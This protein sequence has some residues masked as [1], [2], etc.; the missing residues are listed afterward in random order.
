[1][2]MTIKTMQLNDRDLAILDDLTE[3]GIVDTDIIRRRHFPRD[4]SGKACLR[5]LRLFAA[6]DLLAVLP[7]TVS[8]GPSTAG[9]PL[10]LFRLAERGAEVFATLRRPAPPHTPRREPR[11]DTLLHRLG[12]AKLRLLVN[13]A[14]NLQQLPRGQWIGED[15]TGPGST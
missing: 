11:P 9:R 14:C 10:R 7:I 4:T 2:T 6:H 8:V 3:V 13:D 1:M 5:R 12:I 15:D